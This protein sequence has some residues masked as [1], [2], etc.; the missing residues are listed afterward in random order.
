LFARALVLDDGTTRLAIVVVDT[1]LMPRQLIDEVKQA[2]QASTGIPTARMMIGATHT[3]SA[4]SVAGALGTGVDQRYAEY[5]PGRLVEAIEKAVNNLAP[6][7]VGWARVDAPEHT[8]CRRWILR[9]DRM[10]TDPFGDRT[11]RAMM[12]PGYQNPDYV[13]PAG[14]VDTG[15]S[16]LAVQSPVGRPIAVMANY[17]MHYF[18]CPAVSADY[19]GRFVRKFTEL[20]DAPNVEPPFVAMMCQGTS[21]DLHWMDY[22]QPRKNIGIDTY[23][24]ELAE[25]ARGAYAGIVF[26][27]WVSLAMQETK[28]MLDRRV[29]SEDRL[30]WALAKVEEMAGGKPKDRPEVYAREQVYL[31]Q[32]PT[33]E[34]ILQAIRIGELGITA[35]PCEV[36]GIT[37]LKIKHQSP[38]EMTFNLELTNGAEG[39]IPP[40]E[41]HHLGGYTTWPA[42][43]A[44]LAV[45][46][47][48]R[49]VDTVL[50]LL[51]AVAERPRRKPVQPA[52]P[53]VQAVLD[54]KPVAFWRMDELGGSQAA[55]RSDPATPATYELGIAFFLEGPQ[56]PGFCG[57]QAVNRA[58]HFAGGRLKAQLPSIEDTYSVELWLWNGLPADARP[59]TGY[60]LSRGEDGDPQAAGDHFG[61]GGTHENQA[62]GK[63]MFYNGNSLQE[64]F[65]GQ[66]DIPLK[67]WQHVVFV[68][69]GTRIAVYLNGKQEFEAEAT[70]GH[71][72]NVNQFFFGGRNDNFANLEGKL[73][74]I[75]VYDRALTPGEIEAHFE[76]AEVHFD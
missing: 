20:I 40:P 23:A 12:H 21:G 64:F 71:P 47:E 26:H 60:I 31:Q 52:G 6:A 2:A 51:E 1:L 19:F 3:H 14:P 16:L 49:I 59:V 75:S 63:L 54:S 67:V 42:R 17:S 46:A 45:D 62:L 53:Y 44:A 48:T 10:G 57:P 9:P 11:I 28:L 36:F 70:P 65:A 32:N 25:M 66:T 61:L 56:S 69:D 38:L 18:G 24:E 30:T 4:P 37:G 34:L 27:D 41:Q 5:L 50:G 39:Y 13:G 55:D 73:D 8:H 74:E 58:A 29:P 33:R 72:G 15:L 68:R 22:S 35:I 7:R 76:A 43:S